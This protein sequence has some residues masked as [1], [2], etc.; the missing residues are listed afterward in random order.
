L[1]ESHPYAANWWPDG[2]ALGYEHT[3]VHTL[4]DFLLSL[5]GRKQFSPNFADGV[6]I[7]AVL[8]SA[9]KSARTRRWVEVPL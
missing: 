7:Q 6:Q 1:H 9:L 4:A 2:H 3:F 8:D 5:K